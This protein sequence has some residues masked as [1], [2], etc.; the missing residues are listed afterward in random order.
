MKTF[1]QPMDL[2]LLLKPN[3]NKTRFPKVLFLWAIPQRV[4][5]KNAL[6]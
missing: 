5:R 2:N 6:V 4:Q 3:L 1:S